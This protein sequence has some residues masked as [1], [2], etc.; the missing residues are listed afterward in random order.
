M[1]ADFSNVNAAGVTNEGTYTPDSLFDRDTVTRKRTVASGAGVLP[2]GTLLGKITAS[3]KYLKSIA[4][5]ND[6]SEV[7]DAILLEPVDATAAD[8]EAAVALA[9]EF[10]SKGDH[11]RRGPYRRERR[12]RAPHE[13]YLSRNRRRL[14]RREPGS[15]IKWTFLTPTF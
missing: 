10:A 2:R 3:G 14:T 13:G 4:A 6:G 12:S 5:A 8:A 9:G 7:P 15:L 11:L 1:S